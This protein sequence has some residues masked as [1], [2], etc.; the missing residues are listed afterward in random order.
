MSQSPS[1]TPDFFPPSTP[2]PPT[3]PPIVPPGP[4]QPPVGPPPAPPRPPQFPPQ[5]GPAPSGGSLWIGA[6]Y[7]TLIVVASGAAILI[8]PFISV[9]LLVIGV[10][11][12]VV[13]LAR[14]A[15]T[16]TGVGLLFAYGLLPLVAGGVCVAWFSGA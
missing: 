6:L 4:P 5:G 13:L 16:K 15:T 8:Q 1:D 3:A 10:V 9:A 12:G 14:P 2:Q 7:G 11:I